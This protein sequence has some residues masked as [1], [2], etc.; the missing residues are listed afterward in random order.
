MTNGVASL[1]MAAGVGSRMGFGTH[2]CLTQINGKEFIKLQMEKLMNAYNIGKFFIVVGHKATEIEE[3]LGEEF[4]GAPIQYVFNAHYKDYGSGQSLMLGLRALSE[5]TFRSCD[6]VVTEADCLVPQ[7]AYESLK[8]ESGS[9]CL[10]GPSINIHKSVVVT[11]HFDD[12]NEEDV[13]SF[14]YDRSHRNV[15][16]ELKPYARPIGESI[17]TWYFSNDVLGAYLGASRSL[18]S[19]EFFQKESS[20]LGVM[21]FLLSKDESLLA[22]KAVSYSGT[23]INLNTPADIQLASEQGWCS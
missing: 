21:N 5:S 20:N 13:L 11:V 3:A 14:D 23:F 2:K 16:S 19:S 12:S 6:L 7:E 22:M 9:R 4:M 15:F 8:C 10:V 18:M 1:I 17:Q